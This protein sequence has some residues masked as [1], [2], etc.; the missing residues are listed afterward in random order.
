MIYN[1]QEWYICSFLLA[2]EINHIGKKPNM[3]VLS[4]DKVYRRLTVLP[5]LCK[6]ALQRVFQQDEIVT[7]DSTAYDR[8]QFVHRFFP[9]RRDKSRSSVVKEV[10]SPPLDPSPNDNGFPIHICKQ[11]KHL[12][13]LTAAGYRHSD[14]KTI[15]C[16]YQFLRYN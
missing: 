16:L 8:A 5:E 1:C 14:G 7:V 10:V 3:V 15:N 9:Q 13:L 6:L 12:H 2:A 11:T 4:S